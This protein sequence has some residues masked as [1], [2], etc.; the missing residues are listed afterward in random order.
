MDI[1]KHLERAAEA[2]RKKNFDF[3]I[4]LYN[5]TLAIKPGYREAWLG[6]LR[7]AARRFEYKR[8]PKLMR[9]LQGLPQLV[10]LMI[11]KLFKNNGMIVRACQR[12]LMGDPYH[13][14]VNFLLGNALEA[15]GYLGGASAVYEFV[16]GYDDRNI[17]ALKK[18]GFLTYR[19]K[20]IPT[21][22]ELFEKV[23]AISPRDP[24]AEKMRKNLAAE[25]TLATG[26]YSKAKSSLDLVVDKEETARQQ[27]EIRIHR[28]E[29]E[30]DEET[31]ELRRKV[32]ADPGDNRARRALGE[33]LVRKKEY[34]AALE[35]F[36]ALLE[37]DPSSYDMRC[38]TGDVEILI[39]K[40]NLES[41][42][43]NERGPARKTLLEK[44]VAE[45]SWRVKEHPT[46]LAL[47]FRLGGGMFRTG[48][49]DE[50]IKSFQHSVK[51]PSH[52]VD[53]LLMLG[54]CFRE[55]G[56][57][58]LA[59]K[60]FHTALETTGEGGSRSKE[61]IYD[62]GDVSGKMGDRKA[63]LSWFSK[64]YEVDINYRDVAVKIESLKD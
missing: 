39:L 26:S 49:L 51:D 31:E 30:L 15:S 23:L 32:E 14:S 57:L 12:Y 40:E 42:K 6:L 2:G 61:I 36:K 9:I 19:L 63:A 54:K 7:T 53:S 3:A 46:D 59:L 50:A 25:D 10:V 28:D 20:D 35:F 38:R 55:K 18:A 13:D 45:Y 60:Q 16:A 21:S 24:E 17:T 37:Q 56:L 22:L 47:W 1:S 64:I 41:L 43:E 62:L 48:N 4:S 44:Q 8:T 11:G 5:Q 33:V 29:G 52:K 58:D 27:K 34:G